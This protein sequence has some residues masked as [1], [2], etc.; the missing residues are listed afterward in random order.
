MISVGLDPATQGCC[1]AVDGDKILALWFWRK[2]QR[3]GKKVFI[4][5]YCHTINGEFAFS[6]KQLNSLG[7]VG[8]FLAKEVFSLFGGGYYLACEDS[9]VGRARKT[10]IIVARN[11]GRLV[12]PLEVNAVGSKPNFVRA[13][14][15]RRDVLKVKVSKRE[16]AKAASLSKIPERYP[17]INDIFE[18]IVK[19]D[20]ISDAVGVAT[21]GLNE[22]KREQKRDK[23]SMTT[24]AKRK[25]K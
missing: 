18:R 17:E 13:N 16:D 25:K 14:Q 6:E 2:R 9:Y 4:V 15:W 20:D 3:K 1:A 24:G 7:H 22:W 12:G 19:V 10:S 21:W 5:E 11:S 23:R 8:T